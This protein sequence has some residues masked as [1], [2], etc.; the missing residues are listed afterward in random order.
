M[1]IAVKTKPLFT[2][3]HHFCCC[4]GVMRR[5]FCRVAHLKKRTT[6]VHICTYV[7]M[8][9]SKG[10][11]LWNPLCQNRCICDVRKRESTWLPETFTD[12]SEPKHW[13]PDKRPLP[14]SGGPTLFFLLF[15]QRSTADPMKIKKF[16]MPALRLHFTKGKRPIHTATFLGIYVQSHV[17]SMNVSALL[18][19]L[20]LSFLHDE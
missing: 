14:R 10:P 3:F 1:W 12:A 2:T 18:L 4:T 6:C 19:L 15:V 5:L 13:V 17:W 16:Y 20:L 11:L 8:Y 9:V 7:R